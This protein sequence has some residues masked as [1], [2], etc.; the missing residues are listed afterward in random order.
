MG[1]LFEQVRNGKEVVAFLF[2]DIL[3]LTLPNKP[4]GNTNFQFTPESKMM[5]RMYKNVSITRT[6]F[7]VEQ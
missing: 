1:M 6:F 3:L 7:T 2:N 4:L 5:L